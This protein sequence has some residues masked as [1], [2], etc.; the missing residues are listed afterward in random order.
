MDHDL[1]CPF[2]YFWKRCILLFPVVEVWA[3]FYCSLL[4]DVW[5]VTSTTMKS[6][7][8]IFSSIMFQLHWYILKQNILDGTQVPRQQDTIIENNN[9]SYLPQVMPVDFRA[10][11]WDC[12]VEEMYHFF[13]VQFEFY[14]KEF[15]DL[16]LLE[17]FI[18]SRCA[19]ETVYYLRIVCCSWRNAVQFSSLDCY[20]VFIE[21]NIGIHPLSFT[22]YYRE[23]SWTGSR[24]L[25]SLD[26]EW[27]T[28]LNR[29]LLVLLIV[30]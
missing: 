17:K 1:V 15:T 22:H 9:D 21:S 20:L 2:P 13:L 6:S 12:H 29:Q 18:L 24:T 28:Q 14:P 4:Q 23:F 7:H 16:V 25:I 11:K 19:F 27:D 8:N 26:S 30:Y 3:C 5:S 10:L